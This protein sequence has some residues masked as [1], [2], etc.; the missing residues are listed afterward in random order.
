MRHKYKSFNFT[1]KY[2]SCLH[3]SFKKNSKRLIFDIFPP[4]RVIKNISRELLGFKAEKTKIKKFPALVLRM[5]LII[6]VGFTLL[7]G[8]SPTK[9]LHKNIFAQKGN[10]DITS[11]YGGFCS[12]DWQSANN[13]SG[14]PEL[15]ATSGLDS[16][17]RENSAI[18]LGGNGSI[19]CQEFDNSNLTQDEQTKSPTRH[20]PVSKDI[21][22]SERTYADLN[23]SGVNQDEPFA[24]SAKPAMAENSTSSPELIQKAR[25]FF[26]LALKNNQVPDFISD[27]D[28]DA[29]ILP[30]DET[31]KINISNPDDLNQATDSSQPDPSMP[32]SD[33]PEEQIN[34][35]ELQPTNSSA[36]KDLQEEA[37]N[38]NKNDAANMP[39]S[40]TDNLIENGANNNNASDENDGIIKTLINIWNNLKEYSNP[41]D[42]KAQE[43][44][45]DIGADKAI[46]IWYSL[47]GSVWDKLSEISASDFSNALNNGYLNYDA[48]FLN[49]TQDLKN[50]RIKLEGISSGQSVTAY[51]DSVWVEALSDQSDQSS[52]ETENARL[53]KFDYLFDNLS[54]KNE[55]SINEDA[56]LKFQY[57]K[58]KKSLLSEIG[59][60][61]HI[62]NYWEKVN[63]KIRLLD[64]K[65]KVADLPFSIDYQNDGSINIKFSKLKRQIRP[66]K[67]RIV[68]E[69]DDQT[70]EQPEKIEFNSSFVWGVLAFNSNKSVYNDAETA[71]LQMATL[72]DE[73]DTICDAKLFLDITSPGGEKTTL[74]TED[75]SI[76]KNPKCGPNNVIKNPDYFVFYQTGRTGI[77]KVH[78]AMEANGNRRELN[79]QFEVRK[80]APFDIERIGPTR[81]YPKADYEMKI[82]IRADRDYQGDITEIVPASFKIFNFQFSIFNK[83]RNSK[84][85]IRNSGDEQILIVPDVSIKKGDQV[86]INYTM[87]APDI[88][89]E[90]YLL[91]PL[92]IGS[93]QEKRQW[94]I[95][96]DAVKSRA[97]TVMFMAGTY[98]ND[99]VQT[100]GQSSNTDYAFSTF[101]F[102]LA[103]KDVDIKD[104]FIVFDSQFGSWAGAAYTGYRLAFDSC[105]SATCTPLAFTGT[106][107]ILKDE[108]TTLAYSESESNQGRLLLDV[109]N[110]G[111][112]ASYIGDGAILKGSVGYQFKTAATTNSISYAKAM[113]VLTYTYD[114][115]NSTSTTNTVAY[116]LQSQGS[117]DSG[118]RQNGQKNNCSLNVN[119][120]LFDYNMDIPEF[121]TTTGSTKLSQWFNVRATNDLN[122]TNDITMTVNVDD[123]VY[124]DSSSDPFVHEAALSDQANIPDYYYSSVVGY[125]E[126]MAQTLEIRAS[127]PGVPLYYL[128]G[129]E[130]FETYT[131]SSSA[132]VKTRTVSFPFQV[133]NNGATTAASSSSV[134]VYFPENGLSTGTVAIKKAWVR[135]IS[136]NYNTGAATTTVSTKVGSNAQSSN[137]TY[138]L[139]PSATVINPVF[140][141]IHVLPS[142]DYSELELANATTSKAVTVSATN[143]NNTSQGG[144]SA[145]LMITYTYTSEAGGYLTNLNLFAGQSGVVP[146][147]STTTPTA[148]MVA[149]EPSS[150]TI[151]GGRINASYMFSDSD[152]S[153]PSVYTNYVDANISTGNPICS[154]TLIIGL[155]AVNDYGE[156]YKNVAPMLSTT[157]NQTYNACYTNTNYGGDTSVGA[158]MN[159]ILSY[160]YQW[161][162]TAPSSSIVS[163]AQR[164]DGSGIVD[165]FSNFYDIDGDNLRAKIEFATGTA[166]VFDNPQKL[167]LDDADASASS[168]YGDA[169]IDN[170]S[171]YQIGTTTGWITTSNG[172][173]SVNFDWKSKTDLPAGESTYCLRLT[174]DD[175]SRS[176][177]IPATST[178]FIDNLAPS[179][180]GQLTATSVRATSLKLMFGATSTESN[181]VEYK[182]F[183]KIH[184][185]I[186]VAETDNLLSSTTDQNLG[187]KL[188]NGAASTSL[189]SLLTGTDYDVNIWAYDSYGHKA[190]ATPIQ[191]TTNNYPLGQINS[192]L[193]KTDAS[194]V[195]DISIEADDPDNSDTVRAKI[196][197]VSGA[198]CNFSSPLSPTLDTGQANIQAD[199]G[200]PKVDNGSAYQVGSSSGWI[201]TSPGSNTINIDWLSR[202]DL[203]NENGTI[204]YC[205]R[206]I[207]ND[208]LDDQ[209][210]SATTT[211]TVDNVSPAE[212]G[213]LSNG[214]TTQTT[215]KLIF[216]SQSSDQNFDRYRIFYKQGISGVTE[217][218][219][220]V[221]D[222]NLTYVNYHNAGS[223]TVGS[224]P[225]NTYHVFK[226]WAYDY[227]GNKSSSTETSIRT[228]STITNNLLAL[229]NPPSANIAI[230]DNFTEA[231]FRAIIGESNGFV[232]LASTT[233]KLADKN[234]HDSPFDDLKFTWFQNTGV[235]METGADSLGAAVISPLSTS[236]CAGNTCT[237]DFKIIFNYKFATTS[238]N[239]DAELYS[240]NDSSVSDEDG[241]SSVYQVRSVKTNQLHYRWRNNDGT[242]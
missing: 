70:G 242:Q 157:N 1:S 192:I 161:D 180:P 138:G 12:G 190:S 200:T 121:A 224:L 222:S 56:I 132:A 141:I 104:A 77:Y 220:E 196:E 59:D 166:C 113:L 181:F 115:T 83:I 10:N 219:S 50:L 29:S 4:K 233:L 86:E 168:T 41:S 193:Q 20:T 93:Y 92:S 99:G 186:P 149:P 48:P 24:L 16:F 27:H 123:P 61:L 187:N 71:F 236:T 79:D 150:K 229:I 96:S 159:G 148:T 238:T 44:P 22:I 43:Q 40:A 179:A 34:G 225:L 45:L 165:I 14:L 63:M 152:G 15:P 205:L 116:P 177:V 6:L 23:E 51:L 102:S 215:I 46:I 156:F 65:G 47:D 26:S 7:A 114:A 13:A 208:N 198:A 89:P 39:D 37:L 118:T 162:D 78:L 147:Q 19:I 53:N 182:I 2:R 18:Y 241:Y 31:D 72:D 74:S 142:T 167:T 136:N 91:G 211:F 178:I 171:P 231:N 204:T 240:I 137:F 73:G 98:S 88:S 109:S 188:F 202:Q 105:Q 76:I 49:T 214:G 173:N 94:Q 232:Q 81:I 3:G 60:F 226:I 80:N 8:L 52:D 111:Q 199:Y 217:Q 21:S 117:G 90:F 84:F 143:G 223:T 221:S 54:D 133:I 184:N 35:N 189:S 212:P 108:S 11:F 17:T 82:K 154:S 125:S 55:F 85:E 174:S 194:G 197:Y 69:V 234:D 112:L 175:R 120:P 106:S 237:L 107:S 126:N 67:Y 172:E 239:Y 128:I 62:L 145:E 58:I 75:G 57:K 209:L 122:L 25:I 130:V 100:N 201:M 176:Q 68:F 95:A 210:V 216:G 140:T 131:S 103:E 87:D 66:G 155:D 230:G 207:V 28:P 42:V 9:F 135:I 203:P 101:N 227:Y 169:K 33:N 139:N 129:G 206:L 36:N 170:A 64:A 38:Q 144:V 158:K 228:D 235:F 5:I 183:Y 110:E 30:P 97:K 195:M 151:L 134:N 213:A 146:G 153:M 218:D 163:L 164:R 119:C 127:S 191:F 32:N 185:G 160:T 124:G